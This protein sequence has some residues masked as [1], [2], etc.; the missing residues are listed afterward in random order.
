[1]NGQRT[2]GSRLTRA[3]ALG[4]VLQAACSGSM[5]EEP[6]RAPRKKPDTV[7]LTAQRS[8]KVLSYLGTV[9]ALRDATLSSAQGGLVEDYAVEVGQSVR[10]KDLLVQLGARQMAFASRAAVASA[11]QASARIGRVKDPGSL[12]SVLAAKARL[13]AAT[14]ASRRASQLYTQGS[15]S[16][17]ELNRARTGEAATRAEYDSA[18]AAAG[19]EFGR[20]SELQ[21]V[22]GQTRAALSERKVRAPFDG[23][24]LERFIERGQVAAPNAP[25]VRIVDPSQLHLR[26]DVPQF[27]ADK[28]VIG[29][30][31]N[32]IADGKKLRA[33][34][35]RS[36]PGLVGEA[37]AR[38]VDALLESAPAD[39]LPGTRLT[40]FLELAEQETL[41]AVPLSATTQTAGVVRAWVV[42][43]ERLFE[44]LLSVARIEGNHLFIREG[45]KA[46]DLLVKTPQ[47]DFR[48]GEGVA[49]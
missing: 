25:L 5:Q 8:P 3:L 19:A 27:D 40:V 30:K 45:L 11:T 15:M 18:L 31:V 9:V 48:I 6:K 44:R 21:A 37:G 20:L 12:P 17:Q 22:V 16:E 24:I 4:F 43:Q 13:D 34:I 1:M 39:L 14:D 35:V 7:R 10:E 49:P 38:T 2:R 26:F 29:R 46:G 36:T 33:Q 42:D 41:I 47:T 28:V 23:V 32:A